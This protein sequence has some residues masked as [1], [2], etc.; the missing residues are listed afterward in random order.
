MRYI[1]LYNSHNCVESVWAL[2]NPKSVTA[3]GAQNGHGT[4]EGA[5]ELGVWLGLRSPELKVSPSVDPQTFSS[6]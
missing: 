6:Q 1:T 5:V 4:P 2:G 3:G